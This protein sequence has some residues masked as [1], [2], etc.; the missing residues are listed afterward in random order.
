MD[1]RVNGQ[2]TKTASWKMWY[3]GTVARSGVQLPLWFQV[4]QKSSIGGD[5]II[6]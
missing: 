4:D 6:P 1:V 2:K 5:G 3:K